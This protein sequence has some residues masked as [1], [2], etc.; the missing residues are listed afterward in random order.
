[1]QNRASK[2][3]LAAN[4]I[5]EDCG[6]LSL[7]EIDI[8]DVICSKGIF[9]RPCKIQGSQGRIVM[10]G[11]NAIISYDET[12]NYDSKINFILA[13][14]LGHY[15]M[16]K[17]LL[18]NKMLFND[19]EKTLNEWYAKGVHE[20]EANQFA[21]ELLMPEM[22][23]KSQIDKKTFSIQLMRNVADYFGTSITATIL[24]Y[25]DIGSFPLA[26]VFSEK[27]VIKWVSF[28]E[29]FILRYIPLNEK[30]PENS[31]AEDYFYYGRLPIDCEKIYAKDWF[32][33]HQNIKRHAEMEMYEQCFK[34]SNNDSILSVIWYD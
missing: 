15:E 32:S 28:S 8:K 29:D 25:R 26:I 3:K 34:I 27:K 10:N 31:V 16:H 23:F 21:A 20:T 2:A 9:I 1:M 6:I 17:S 11:N 7:K 5:L 12:I 13:H 19:D 14:E 4:K 30:I 24:R 18:Q 33:Y 22:L